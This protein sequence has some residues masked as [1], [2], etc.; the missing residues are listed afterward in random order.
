M[1][2]L[3]FRGRSSQRGQSMSLGNLFL[4]FFLGLLHSLAQKFSIFYSLFHIFLSPLILQSNTHMLIPAMQDKW[5]NT[6]LNLGCF[7]PSL[8]SLFRGLLTAYWRTSSSSESVTSL[9]ILLALLG[10]RQWG[11]VVSARPGISFSPFFYRPSWEHSDWHPQ[12]NLQETGALSRVLLGL[13]QECPLLRSRQT[14][15]WVKT[16]CFM[17]KPCL[18]FPPLT[19]TTITL[20]FFTQ[21]VSSNFCDHM[22]LIKV[23]KLPFIIHFNEFLAASVLERDVQLYPEVATRLQGTTKKQHPFILLKNAS[24]GSKH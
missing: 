3:K 9:W 15:P 23:T 11:T 6:M 8:P 1:T 14:P 16:H 24:S 12:R 5:S 18:S 2:R 4:A 10:P 21:S 17:G 20:P 13:Y 19:G 7:G 22:L